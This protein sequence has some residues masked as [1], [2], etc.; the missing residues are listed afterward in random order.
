[1]RIF[2]YFKLIINFSNKILLIIPGVADVEKNKSVHLKK[3]FVKIF[4]LKI[5]KLVHARN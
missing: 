5:K 2:F 4:T 1:M 3:N